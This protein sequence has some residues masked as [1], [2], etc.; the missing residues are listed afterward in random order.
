MP[1]ELGAFYLDIII[2]C[3]CTFISILFGKR[4]GDHY[5][6]YKIEQ[7]FPRGSKKCGGIGV[8]YL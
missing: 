4:K 1:G 8:S 6:D 5:K 2:W 3:L 7:I